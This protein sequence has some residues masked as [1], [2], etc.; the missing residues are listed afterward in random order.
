MARINKIE[1][2]PLIENLDV[3]NQNLLWIFFRRIHCVI[4]KKLIIT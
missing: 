2:E 1:K 3:D 4:T